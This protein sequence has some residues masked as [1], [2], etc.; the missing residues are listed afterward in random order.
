M[1]EAVGRVRMGVRSENVNG[2]GVALQGP[3]C[4]YRWAGGP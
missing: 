4:C 2:G 1:A 3:V